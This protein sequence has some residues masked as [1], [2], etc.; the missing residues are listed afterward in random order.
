MT[1][2]P[3]FIRAHSHCVSNLWS[4]LTQLRHSGRFDGCSS[5][6][7]S[8]R[9]GRAWKC[10]SRKYSQKRRQESAPLGAQEEDPSRRRVNRARARSH[11]AALAIGTGSC[12]VTDVLRV[13][14]WTDR[15]PSPSRTE[16]SHSSWR[17]SYGFDFKHLNLDFPLNDQLCN[18]STPIN[19]KRPRAMVYQDHTD[20]P[21]VTLVN[22]SWTIQ[23]GD[24]PFECQTAQWSN[25]ALSPWWECHC[26]PR[27]D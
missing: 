1:G 7:T 25:L 27:L 15:T 8:G 12:G 26:D 23:Y 13:S 19:A 10:P 22:R 11:S 18:T 14:Q 24:R 21:A 6:P 3:R 5:V 16:S 2:Q 17:V 20:L 9:F 4:A